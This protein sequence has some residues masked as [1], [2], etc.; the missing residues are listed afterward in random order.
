MS[1]AERC[2][3]TVVGTWGCA[4]VVLVGGGVPAAAA[5]AAHGKGVYDVRCA[6]CH[7]ENGAG[8]GPAAAAIVPKPRNFRDPAFW[9]ARSTQ[10]LRLA[11]RDGRPGTLMAPFAGVLSDAEIDDV[12]T[13]VQSFRPAGP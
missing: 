5:D 13:Y 11:V 9:K 2:R 7:G 10:Q 12:V 1:S 3:R 8:D 6:P 4:V